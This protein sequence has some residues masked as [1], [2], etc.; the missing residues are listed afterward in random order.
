MKI[1]EFPCVIVDSWC[2]CVVSTAFSRDTF[3]LILSV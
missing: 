2:V 1:D 3:R